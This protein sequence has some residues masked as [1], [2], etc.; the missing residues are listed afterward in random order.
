MIPWHVSFF[1]REA[2]EMILTTSI[3]QLSLGR[4]NYTLVLIGSNYILWKC[5]NSALFLHFVLSE[6]HLCSKC[7]QR[8]DV[9]VLVSTGPVQAVFLLKFLSSLILCVYV[10]NKVLTKFG[11]DS[12]IN[13]RLNFK[14]NWMV[15]VDTKQKRY[16]MTNKHKQQTLLEQGKRLHSWSCDRLSSILKG[17]SD[18]EHGHCILKTSISNGLCLCQDFFAPQIQPCQCNA[19]VSH[20]HSKYHVVLERVFNHR[21]SID[22]AALTLSLAGNQ[23]WRWKWNSWTQ[24]W[25]LSAL[26]TTCKTP[27]EFFYFFFMKS[28]TSDNCRL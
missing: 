11:V 19:E 16:T 3:Q 21:K 13:Q 5:S 6:E 1:L 9:L 10:Q 7:K 22:G 26:S 2:P 24:Q 25:A 20:E 8:S 18:R 28:D 15:N 17:L 4:R 23:G 12:K 14:V 27:T